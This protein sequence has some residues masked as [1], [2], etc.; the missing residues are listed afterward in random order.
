L[1]I[2]SP[3]LGFQRERGFADLY[4]QVRRERIEYTDLSASWC[5]PATMPAN[6]RDDA[7]GTGAA[8]R[9]AH[10]W[11]TMALEWVNKRINFAL[12][13]GLL[14]TLPHSAMPGGKLVLFALAM[15]GLA[16]ATMTTHGRSRSS[17]S[18]TVWRT[19]VAT[20]AGVAA[21]LGLGLNEFLLARI[22]SADGVLSPSSVRT[23]RMVE[24]GLLS[25]AAVLLATRRSIATVLVRLSSGWK[26]SAPG[27]S[28]LPLAL[29]IVVPWMT[30]LL[31]VDQDRRFWWIWP[32]QVIVLAAAVTRIP[33]ASSRTVVGLAAALVAAMVF[34]NDALL[35]R[36]MDWARNGWGGRDAPEVALIDRLAGRIMSTGRQ[37]ASIGYEVEIWRF[38]AQANIADPR[39]KA[40]ADFDMLLLHRHGIENLNR[41]AEGVSPQDDYRIVQTAARSS[42]PL[43]R[44]RVNSVRSDDFRL[45]ER[46]GVYDILQRD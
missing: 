38:M 29:A 18:P 32:V 46:V 30:L 10:A 27:P 42:D 3:Y 34:F 44:N 19:R 25:V 7:R 14:A 43:A 24:V 17:D 41:C 21:L 36:T 35:S 8:T 45:V 31:L 15:V 26:A 9:P 1:L 28:A 6:W 20:A 16:S 12:D 5:D 39:Y 4:S 33:L 11:T 23:I 22:A 2:W 37:S 40:G 13:G